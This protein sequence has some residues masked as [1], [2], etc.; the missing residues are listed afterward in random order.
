M[1]WVLTLFFLW[2]AAVHQKALK[3]VLQKT[4]I[5]LHFRVAD[6]LIGF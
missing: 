3:C 2:L 5:L 4:F 1:G 6:F